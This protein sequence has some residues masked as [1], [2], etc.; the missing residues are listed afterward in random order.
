MLYVH[1]VPRTPLGPTERDECK[2]T[3]SNGT[4]NHR[5]Y[6][7][8]V[9]LPLKQAECATAPEDE[10]ELDL[11]LSGGIAHQSSQESDLVWKRE[12]AKGGLDVK[13]VSCWHAR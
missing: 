2:H 7:W 12:L 8:K 11:Y 9:H 1:R 5:S 13:G 4:L 10:G 3:H 6:A